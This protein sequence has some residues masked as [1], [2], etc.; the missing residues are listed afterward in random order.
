MPPGIRQGIAYN[1]S[2]Q[3][4][5]EVKYHVES[6]VAVRERVA[7]NGGRLDQT[8]QHADRYF[9][10]PS[11]DFAETDEALRVRV[12][13]GG[14]FLTYKGPRIDAATKTRKE[15]QI[16]LAD[17]NPS[18]EILV[19]ILLS[20]GFRETLAVRKT[21]EIWHMD[22]AVDIVEVGLDTVAELGS[23]VELECIAAEADV[24]AARTAIMD[25]GR[26]LGLERMERRSYLE[27][28]LELRKV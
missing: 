25:L 12:S 23:F 2:V 7:A 13:P 9:N 1:R 21:R 28:L 11:R 3:Y 8:E 27:L 5:V 26:R 4:E 20:L 14:V 17:G 18:V 16:A 22:D 10:H 6:L 15:L 19:Q 24:A